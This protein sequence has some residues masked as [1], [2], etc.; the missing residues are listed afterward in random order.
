MKDIF[1][2]D[3]EGLLFNSIYDDLEG[4]N[5][6]TSLTIPS[7]DAIIYENNSFFTLF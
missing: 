1:H 7:K 2:N 6:A 5:G 4:R 3:L